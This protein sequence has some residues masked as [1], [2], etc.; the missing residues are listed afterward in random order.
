M[1][2][3]SEPDAYGD[4]KVAES[5]ADGR[6]NKD[7]NDKGIASFGTYNV[8][9]LNSK[10]GTKWGVA[11]GDLRPEYSAAYSSKQDGDYTEYYNQGKQKQV[12]VNLRSHTPLS[13]CHMHLQSDYIKTQKVL[14]PIEMEDPIRVCHPKGLKNQQFHK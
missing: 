11:H 6:Q 13:F 5:N 10:Y 14:P 12:I 2:A 7:N 4:F 1:V 8:N 9:D 3:L